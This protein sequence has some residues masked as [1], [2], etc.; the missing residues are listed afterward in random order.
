MPRTGPTI[1]QILDDFLSVQRDRVKVSTARRYEE[2]L[3][4]LRS[5]IDGYG[6]QWLSEK[7][8]ELFR[9]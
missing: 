4:Y 2:V 5:C 3:D 1:N 8:S 9:I 6:H 7:D